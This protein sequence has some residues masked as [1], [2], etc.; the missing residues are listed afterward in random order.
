MTK[1]DWFS[2]IE[3]GMA[4]AQAEKTKPSLKAVGPGGAGGD[5]YRNTNN[6]NVL[7]EACACPTTVGPDGDAERPLK[8]KQLPRAVP[9]L[10]HHL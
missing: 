9:Q 4:A 2:A 5:L 10:P 8:N 1:V 6:I 3:R 7:Q